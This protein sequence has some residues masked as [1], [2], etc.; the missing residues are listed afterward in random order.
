V[1]ISDENLHH[2]RELMDEVFGAENACTT[3]LMRK[4]GWAASQLLP[5]VHDF[6]LWYARDRE[7]LKFDQL[8][9]PKRLEDMGD[10]S[11][12]WVE[13]DDGR[14][15]RPLTENERADPRSIPVGWRLFFHDNL[16]SEGP[17]PTSSGP[18]KFEGKE[19]WPGTG[20]RVD[21]H[22]KTVPVGLDKLATENRLLAVGD[23][24]R[25]K[26]YFDVKGLLHARP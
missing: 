10:V 21:R 7:R 15:R 4:S 19:Y 26:R 11:G 5:Q 9:S 24:L 16:T 20:K 17:S 13:T 8:F 23:T 25:Q 1:Q 12:A 2:V 18:Y 6:L 22:W 3:V 14:T